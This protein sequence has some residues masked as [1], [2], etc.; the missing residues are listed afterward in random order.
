MKRAKP[1]PLG[2]LLL[3]LGVFSDEADDV[4]LVPYAPYVV[5]HD[6]HR[7]NVPPA[8]RRLSGNPVLSDRSGVLGDKR[9][10]HS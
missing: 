2:A 9:L 5:V 6:A 1:H 4:G 7:S 8:L 3:E 10:G